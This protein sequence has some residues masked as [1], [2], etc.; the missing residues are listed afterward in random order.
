MS[1][2]IKRRLLDIDNL[3]EEKRVEKWWNN[4]FIPC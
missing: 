1:E 4:V 3:E 2:K